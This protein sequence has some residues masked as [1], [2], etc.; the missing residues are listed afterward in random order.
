MKNSKLAQ[1]EI[2]GIQA[3]LNGKKRIP[4][5]DKQ[6][7]DLCD[8]PIGSSLPFMNAL[9]KNWDFSNLSQSNEKVEVIARLE[10]NIS[11]LENTI[12]Q[13]FWN[14]GYIENCKSSIASYKAQIEELKK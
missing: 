11:R 14:K 3:F 10:E 13:G 4:C 1:A 9:M 12:K 5:L 6:L 8:G 2:L 7:M